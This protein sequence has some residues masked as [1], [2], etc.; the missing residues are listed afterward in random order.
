MSF[1]DI[2][3]DFYTQRRFYRYLVQNCKR[4]GTTRL[5][6]Q[7]HMHTLTTQIV[8]EE[9]ERRQLRQVRKTRGDRSC[10]KL[11]RDNP[12]DL[13]SMFIMD[14]GNRYAPYTAATRI[15]ALTTLHALWQCRKNNVFS[16]LQ[17]TENYR[18]RLHTAA[19]SHHSPKLRWP[20]RTC[21]R[22]QLVMHNLT[23]QFVAEE[24]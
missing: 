9:A 4:Q 8:A 22:E 1:I 7:P 18:R 20:G 19:T 5:R 12:S 17:T 11:R 13:P 10:V 6:Q 21:R 14:T 24:V 3:D 16:L 15:L 23:A 2:A